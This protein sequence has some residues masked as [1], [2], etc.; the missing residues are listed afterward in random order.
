MTVQQIITLN[1]M[2]QNLTLIQEYSQGKINKD[3]EKT[4]ICLQCL[5]FARKQVMGNIK[6]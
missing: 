3:A 2:W 6:Y 4:F 1:M 5:S